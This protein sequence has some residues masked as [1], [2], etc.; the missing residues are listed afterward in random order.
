[1]QGKILDYSSVN[2]SGVI[3]V[4]NG[5]KYNFVK[6]DL[7][8]FTEE[9]K[10]G[11]LVDFETLGEEAKNIYLDLCKDDSFTLKSILS[12]YKKAF[13]H[14]FDFKGTAKRTEFWYFHLVNIIA[15][16]VLTMASAGVLGMLY[17][18]IAVIPALSIGAR[19][20]H[21]TGKS[22]WWQLLILIPVVGI[23]ILIYLCAKESKTQDNK[24]L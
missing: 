1:M 13:R 11:Q 7:Q 10:V 15:I 22:A 16:A 21:D 3:G 23:L 17:N 12:H 6:A 4:S 2:L 8:E 5:N 18:I 14:Y 24:Y 9:P 19:R 20:L